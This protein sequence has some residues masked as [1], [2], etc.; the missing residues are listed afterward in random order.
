[1]GIESGPGFPAESL[2]LLVAARITSRADC[3]SCLPL[4]NLCVTCLPSCLRIPPSLDAASIYIYPQLCTTKRGTAMRNRILI[5]D[6][7]EKV[8]IALE[9]ALE[10]EGYET[11]TAWDLPEGLDVLAEGGF[12]LLLVGDHP[13]ELNCERV[14]KVLHR[15]GVD[16]PVVVMHS[17][18]RHPFAEA[19][20]THLG[21]AGVV[22]KW[23]E[24]Q[25]VDIVRSCF[26]IPPQ[27]AE[28]PQRTRAAAN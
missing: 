25:V 12:H 15:E 24:R 10:Q 3:L 6:N 11:E 1:M 4:A 20:I 21:A 14:L 2:E 16:L 18:P 7:D 13:P 26:G 17:Q 28:T 22:C 23:N 27:S 9:R 8:L 19:F 5:V